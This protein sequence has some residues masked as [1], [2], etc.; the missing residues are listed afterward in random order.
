VINNEEQRQG[1]VGRRHAH[2]PYFF[3]TGIFELD[4]KNGE[5]MLRGKRTKHGQMATPDW[6]VV[7]YLV[8]EDGDAQ[9]GFPLQLLSVGGR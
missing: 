6:I 9:A 5:I 1:P 3:R 8:V 2:K 4:R 7:R